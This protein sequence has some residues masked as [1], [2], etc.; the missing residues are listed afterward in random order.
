MLA[1]EG[2][3]PKAPHEMVIK[4]VTVFFLDM[5]NG[6]V[7]GRH[8]KLLNKIKFFGIDDPFLTWISSYQASGNHGAQ[9]N[10]LIPDPD[11]VTSGVIKGGV[12][13][14]CFS[15]LLSKIEALLTVLLA[16][17]KCSAFFALRP[18]SPP[19]YCKRSKSLPT[20]AAS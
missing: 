13:R 20:K 19:I 7:A 1:R 11:L 10:G 17:S 14:P 16:I 12:P 15:D 4:E 9:L 18:W 2:S 6:F 3:F 8:R 5:T